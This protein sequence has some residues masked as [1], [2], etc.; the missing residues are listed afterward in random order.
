MHYSREILWWKETG[1]SKLSI[2]IGIRN[3]AGPTKISDNQRKCQWKKLTR[4]KA[5]EKMVS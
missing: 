3:K 5:K 4:A 1:D 2:Y